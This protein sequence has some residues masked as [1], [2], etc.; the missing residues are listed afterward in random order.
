MNTTEEKPDTQSCEPFH[1]AP[2]GEVIRRHKGRGGHFFDDDTMKFFNTCF[3]G[4]PT[5]GPDGYAYGVVSNKQTP[6]GR[7]GHRTEH[8]RRYQVIRCAPDGSIE[9]PHPTGSPNVADFALRFTRK[10]NAQS[11]VDALTAE[12]TDSDRELRPENFRW[13]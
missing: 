10:E 5:V 11:A 8:P 13:Y 3:H 12:P 7:P 1:S 4:T 9:R 6:T 2:W